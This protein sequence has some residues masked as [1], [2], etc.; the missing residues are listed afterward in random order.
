MHL[1]NHCADQELIIADSIASL[2]NVFSSRS[3]HGH[4]IPDCCRCTVESV[5]LCR[6]HRL[7]NKSPDTTGKAGQA[8]L[9]PKRES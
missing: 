8:Q 6:A 7:P 3:F 9:H 5:T 1:T 2:N 4:A